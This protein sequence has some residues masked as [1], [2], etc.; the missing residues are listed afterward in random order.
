MQAWM[1]GYESDIEYTTGYYREQ[2]PDFLNLCAATHGVAPIHLE[3]GF[4]YCEL[5]CG[6]G[7]TALIM[8][9][10]YPQGKFYAV[11]FNPSH[12]ARAR[13]LAAEAGLTNIV[14]LEKSFSQIAEDS[15]LLPEC[16]FIVL[17]GIFTWVSDDNRQHIIDICARHLRS[18][19]MVYNSYNAKP[20]WSMGEPIQKMLF[21]AGKLFSGNSISRFE[22]SVQLIKE[23]ETVGPRFFALNKE[24]IQKRLEILSSKDKHY[25]V[26]EYFHEGWRAF[27]FTEIAE[28]MASAK[29]DFIGEAS[30]ASAYIPQ[31]MPEKASQFLQKIPDVNVRELFKDVTLNTMFRKDMYM[32]GITDKLDGAKQTHFFRSTR[33]MARKPAPADHKFEFGLAIGTVTGKQEVYRPIMD[34]LGQQPMGFGDLQQVVGV[35]AKELIQALMLLSHDGMVSRH[36]ETVDVA[37]SALRLNRLLA[38]QAFG[39]AT[40]TYVALPRAKAAATLAMPALMFYSAALETG[41]V[42]S[43]ASLVNY[44]A[45]Q[46]EARGLNIRHGG[47]ELTGDAMKA[48]LHEMEQAW[49]AEVLPILR[50]GG[51]LG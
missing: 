49:R 48:R 44:V 51:A 41:E 7:M 43:P 33:W 26:H 3:K 37:P 50:D 42:E 34:A 40:G 31:F 20:G 6:Q 16:D 32:R 45:E 29:L 18:G 28:Y 22:Q 14:F 35:S 4:T 27:Y 24:V 1:E 46:F 38:S 36:F 39:G 19:G 25:L 23:L 17:H 13:H 47:N 8:A 9:A 21:A 2:E 5:G 15:S 12:I 10:N 30:T 11:D